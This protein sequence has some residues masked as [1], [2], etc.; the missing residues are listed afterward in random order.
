MPA[1]YQT[2][3]TPSVLAPAAQVIT[4]NTRKTSLSCFSISI[5][6]SKTNNCKKKKKVLL[7]L[8]WDMLNMPWW[9]IWMLT[10]HTQHAL[11]A[12]WAVPPFSQLQLGCNPTCILGKLKKKAFQNIGNLRD[13]V[14]WQSKIITVQKNKKIVN[15]KC[16]FLCSLVM[17][18]CQQ[19]H[20]WQPRSTQ[21]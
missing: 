21:N 17:E 3:L 14:T 5:Q 4:E 7:S 11:N 12:R 10:S 13:T 8:V 9:C 20:D 6:N 2:G 16:Y 15:S 1:L 18:C 19:W